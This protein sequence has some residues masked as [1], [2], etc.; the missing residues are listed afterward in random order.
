MTSIDGTALYNKILAVDF[1]GASGNVS[2]NNASAGELYRGDRG[3]ALGYLVRNYNSS[4]GAFHTLGSW[5]FVAGASWTQRFDDAL[6][7]RQTQTSVASMHRT[8]GTAVGYRSPATS[9]RCV[10]CSPPTSRWTR[11]SHGTA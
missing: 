7:S 3:V 11:R 6:A 9:P 5:T 4:G 2:F 8:H 1:E 10:L